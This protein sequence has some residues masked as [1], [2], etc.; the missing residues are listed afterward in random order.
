MPKT[1]PEALAITLILA[2]HLSAQTSKHVYVSNQHSNTLSVFSVDATSGNLAAAGVISTPSVPQ[3]IVFNPLGTFGYLVS[4]NGG[5]ASLTTWSV[6]STGQLTQSGS[7]SL[8]GGSYNVPVVD[9]SG[10]YLILSSASTGKISAYRLDATSGAPSLVSS[11]NTSNV[12]SSVAFLSQGQFA[13]ASGNV[14]SVAE[15]SLDKTS[16]TLSKV[17][18]VSGLTPASP[19]PG[20]KAPRAQLT[21]VQ[22]SGSFVYILDPTTQTAKAYSY[23]ST[24][25]ALTAVPGSFSIGVVA[26]DVVFHPS[27]KFLYVGDW[28]TGVI[29][30]FLVSAN[31]ALTSI[32][33]SPFI[34]PFVTSSHRGG[35]VCLTTDATGQFLYAISGDTSQITGFRIDQTTG[36]LTQISGLLLSTGGGA[37]KVVAGP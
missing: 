14:P 11:I 20:L 12:P 24:D 25:G 8:N 16:G 6:G 22:P 32:A 5:T 10:N 2:L 29:A 7:I 34:T 18:Q 19:I 21:A 3:H 28:H 9:P 23:N 15:M 26:N 4:D 1:L 35:N 13:L 30:G 31:G 37:Y 36:A 33:G 27:G 17:G